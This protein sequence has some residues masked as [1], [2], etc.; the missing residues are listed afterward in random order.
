MNTLAALVALSLSCL[1][2]G[3]AAAQ[4]SSPSRERRSAANAIRFLPRYLGSA[5]C[6]QP[7]PF[8]QAHL[9]TS[10]VNPS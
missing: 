8:P 10:T 9:L 3:V 5:R 2:A 6:R 4:P 1:A 7:G